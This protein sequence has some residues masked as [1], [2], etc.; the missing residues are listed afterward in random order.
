MNI[1]ISFDIGNT[2]LDVGG[3]NNIHDNLLRY[4]NKNRISNFILNYHCRLKKKSID[5][6]CNQLSLDFDELYTLIKTSAKP[7]IYSDVFPV[8]ENFRQKGIKL[9]IISNA[10]SIIP[11]Y[12]GD[13]GLT[14]YFELVLN[15]YDF[16]SLKPSKK[17]FL[18]AQEYFGNNYLYMHIGDNIYSD[19]LGANNMNWISVMM[20]RNWEYE[21]ER[22][23]RKLIPNYVVHDL[24][25]LERIV[26]FL[27]KEER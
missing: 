11:D 14:Y 19:I 16:G 22:L 27:Q 5:E 10:L 17:M 15:S 13:Y 12:I 9:I 1:V 26:D 7:S 8:L 2:L 25:G 24:Y 6:L 4:M 3:K 20:D 18:Y 21:K 23:D